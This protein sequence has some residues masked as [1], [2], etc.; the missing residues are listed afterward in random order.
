MFCKSKGKQ[1][2]QSS[3]KVH[4]LVAKRHFLAEKPAAFVENQKAERFQKVDAI[5]A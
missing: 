3:Y 5:M 1:T 4:K 2:E